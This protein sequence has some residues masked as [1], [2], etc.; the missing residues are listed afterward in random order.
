[1]D[2]ATGE[3]LCLKIINPAISVERLDRELQALTSLNHKNL[4]R[5]HAYHNTITRNGHKHAT[6][7]PF[8]QGADLAS[9]ISPGTIWPL[10]EAAA[11]F[12]EV[13]DG[14]AVLGELHI[15]HRD[16]KPTNIRIHSSGYPVIID[17]GIARHLLLDPLTSTGQGARLGSQPYL[18]PEQWRGSYKDIDPRSDLFAVG[19]MLYEAVTGRH[20]F[21]TTNPITVM[22]LE[23]NACDHDYHLNFPEFRS[24]PGPW[25]I[26]V[27]RL[28]ERS[29]ERRPLDAKQA[30]VV[31]RKIGGLP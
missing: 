16:L 21:W 29:R 20:P 8:I 19:I 28:L 14:L 1:M 30:A 7:E 3:E 5:L 25:Q 24:L 12:G 13:L 11:F 22:Q 31:L 26:T 9:R 23:Q 17:F 10:D 2:D 15:V 18:S 6:V 4:S 27:G